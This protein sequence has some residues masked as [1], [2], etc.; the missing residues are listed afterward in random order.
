MEDR[1]VPSWAVCQAIYDITFD[2]W[3]LPQYAAQPDEPR[4]G[5]FAASALHDMK[6]DLRLIA[7]EFGKYSADFAKLGSPGDVVDFDGAHY[8]SAHHA[9]LGQSKNV[10]ARLW[11]QMAPAE[12]RKKTEQSE[13][14]ADV[15]YT[16]GIEPSEVCERWAEARQILTRELPP[17]WQQDLSRLC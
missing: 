16:I 13:C 10:L 17:E 1:S 12:M 9:V 8:A 15:V 3:R 5:D 7:P 11:G 6:E 4:F 2:L 14:S